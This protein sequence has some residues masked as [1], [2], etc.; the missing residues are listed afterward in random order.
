MPAALVHAAEEVLVYLMKSDEAVQG[1]VDFR[2]CPD[3]LPIEWKDQTA[4]V[5]EQHADKR[6]RLING[7][8]TGLIHSYF[9]IYCIDRNRAKSRELA[10]AIKS[11][12]A[13]ESRQTIAEVEVCQVFVKDG[14]HDV[15]VP[16]AD[17][18]DQPERYRTLE[19]VIHYRT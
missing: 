14:D 10:R 9:T 16:S 18:I 6:Q 15:S 17:G 13:V 5:Y 2:I 8:G 7:S 4:I 3:Q 19:C 1:L 11:A 12:I